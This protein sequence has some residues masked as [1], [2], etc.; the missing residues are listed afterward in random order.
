MKSYRDR[1]NPVRAVLFDVDGTLA[2]TERDGHRLAFNA[3]F[4]TKCGRA[5]LRHAGMDDRFEKTLAICVMKASTDICRIE[6]MKPGGGYKQPN[7]REACE[8]YG[9]VN[10]KAHSA[11]GDA[12]AAEAIFRKLHAMGKLP[13]PRP[14]TAP[15]R[16]CATT[17]P[18][19]GPGAVAS[20]PPPR[21]AHIATGSR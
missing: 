6:R 11:L 2:D 9:I 5:E 8:F 13:A 19:P 20:G 1:D 14:E 4:D 18:P 10:Q 12:E 16:R 7:L 17:Q 3:A 21:P 15:P